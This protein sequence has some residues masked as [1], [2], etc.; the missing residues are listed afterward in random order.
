MLQWADQMWEGGRIKVDL[1]TGEYLPYIERMVRG[2]RYVIQLGPEDPT[3]K[4]Y[5]E[6]A[7]LELMLFERDAIAY[8]RAHDQKLGKVVGRAVISTESIQ[9][10]ADQLRDK[11]RNRHHVKN[12]VR[13]LIAWGEAFKGRDLRTISPAEIE[14]FK[15]STATLARRRALKAFCNWM[16]GREL[17]RFDESPTRRLKIPKS[18][19]AK[20]GKHMGYSTAQ[21]E[22]FYS[23][24]RSQDIRDVIL[25][26]AKYG[27]HHTEIERLVQDGTVREIHDPCGIAAVI[28]FL[29]KSGDEHK[30]SVDALA[31]GAVRRLQTRG[32]APSKDWVLKLCHKTAEQNKIPMVLP[33]EL[34]H[35]FATWMQEGGEIITRSG[36]AVW[37]TP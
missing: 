26:R 12:C 21:V 13:H 8:K 17:L 22:R 1:E 28:S 20:A 36:R 9:Q 25:L 23:A 15:W 3:D 31:L 24:I 32:Y 33:E 10:Y 34:R 11:G 37:R 5:L 18:K 30:L 27:M 4:K 14:D 19:V 2:I 35:S 29:H 7:K 6:H 16:V